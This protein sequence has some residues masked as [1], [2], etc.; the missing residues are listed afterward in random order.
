MK[1]SVWKAIS[2]SVLGIMCIL[3]CF[4]VFLL[5]VGALAGERELMV[6]LQGL[7]IKKGQSF[8]TDAP[9]VFTN[10]KKRF[11]KKELTQKPF[12]KTIGKRV[13]QRERKMAVQ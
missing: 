13:C 8:W 3:S 4:P 11:W 12:K 10:E 6:Y 7:L 2:H 5:A 9:S 1:R